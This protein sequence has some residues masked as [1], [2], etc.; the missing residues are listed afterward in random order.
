MPTPTQ[1]SSALTFS[2]AGP[3][4]R[5]LNGV[6][7]G[8]SLIVLV[9]GGNGGGTPGPDWVGNDG[10]AYTSASYKQASSGLAMEVSVL[11]RHNVSA[12]NYTVSISQSVPTVARCIFLEVAGLTNGAQDSARGNNSGKPF[13][14]STQTISSGSTGTLTNA[15]S[16]V[17]GLA[18]TSDGAAGAGFTTPSGYTSLDL[19]T[20]GSGNW[21][22]CW[23]DV[24]ATTAINLAFGTSANNYWWAA[25]AVAFQ[26][27]SSGGRLTGPLVGGT[28][29]GTLA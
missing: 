3:F 8:S 26:I 6:A 2:G 24:A 16:M 1:A 14:G 29:I 17:F 4:T 23:K 11:Y 15:S 21:Q 9:A 18:M 25:S 27:A 19:S 12:G 22:F 20:S 5:T 7:A 10:S 28:L 13:D